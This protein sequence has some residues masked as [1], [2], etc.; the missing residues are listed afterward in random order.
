MSLS[1]V[2]FI[3]DL[4]P[5]KEQYSDIN[6]QEYSH[7]FYLFANPRSGDRT[8]LKFINPKFHQFRVVFTK[9]ECR[10]LRE[11]NELSRGY[12]SKTLTS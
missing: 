4:K 9:D 1:E 10:N 6:L 12:E 3:Q 5:L 11:R 8:A 2:E 7:H